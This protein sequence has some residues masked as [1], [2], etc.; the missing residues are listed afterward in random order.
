MWC[1]VYGASVEVSHR[2]RR[3]WLPDTALE[4]TLVPRIGCAVPGWL[5]ETEDVVAGDPRIVLTEDGEEHVASSAHV[6]RVNA[7]SADVLPAGSIARLLFAY[8]TL[9]EGEPEHARV[10]KVGR[11]E[12][13]RIEGR[14]FALPAGYPGAIAGKGS[15]DGQLIEIAGGWEELD[16]YEGFAG[17]GARSLFR[18]VIVR[19]YTPSRSIYAW[20]YFY[21]GS[22]EGARPITRWRQ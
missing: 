8:G 6:G 7:L 21:A 16:R 4:H 18:R 20:T 5:I 9:M 14:L 11:V 22:R 19:V 17:Y 3:A 10:Q 1:F 2:A 15:I 12:A 13:A